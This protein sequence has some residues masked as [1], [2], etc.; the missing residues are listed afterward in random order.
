VPV[1][2]SRAGPGRA[3]P[4]HPLDGH[5]GPS[6]ALGRDAAG[7]RG[8]GC[9][10]PTGRPRHRGGRRDSAAGV[11]TRRSRPSG[12][13]R[14]LDV[15]SPLACFKSGPALKRGH[16]FHGTVEAHPRRARSLPPGL[17][18]APSSRPPRGRSPPSAARPPSPGAWHGAVRGRGADRRPGSAISESEERSREPRPSGLAIGGP[19]CSLLVTVAAVLVWKPVEAQSRHCF[20][21][22]VGKVEAQSSGQ[23]LSLSSKVVSVYLNRPS[24]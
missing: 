21:A 18:P 15:H 8:L 19:R 12:V 16:G 1:R 24:Q 14:G 13:E 5:D 23:D 9:R 3:G 4:D 7:R 22:I 11:A 20:V 10:P 17:D 6:I 2:L